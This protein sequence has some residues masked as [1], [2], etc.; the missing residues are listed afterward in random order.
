MT[1]PD[2]IFRP[3]ALQLH[4]R[5]R[6]DADGV[7]R[8]GPR[9]LRRL[10]VLSLVLVLAGLAAVWLIPIEETATGRAVVDT[11][12]GSVVALLPAGTAPELSGS[13]GLRVGLPGQPGRMVPV[14]VR[15]AAPADDETL[16]EA[17]LDPLPQGGLL[18]S[19]RIRDAAPERP[20]GQ[21]TR[22]EVPATV[23]LRSERLADVLGRQ[24][25][26]ML[27]SSEAGP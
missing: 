9:W 26:Q 21:P 17:G 19:G 7:V 6:E 24:V 5:G 15:S 14:E 16:R 12:T 10:Y 22:I 13:A 4:A 27:G 23:V 3:E 11:R 18:L 2:T 20:G 25:G 1:E 8:L